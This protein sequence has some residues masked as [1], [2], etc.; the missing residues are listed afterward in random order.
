V[1]SGLPGFRFMT[2][3]GRTRRPAKWFVNEGA[4]TTGSY[5]EVKADNI[6]STGPLD[7]GGA[8]LIRLVGKTAGVD[9]TRVRTGNSSLASIGSID[10]ERR[11]YTNP[12]G[13]TDAYWGIGSNGVFSGSG[14][15]TRLN[16]G[17]FNLP[18]PSTPPHQNEFLSGRRLAT[19]RV[20]LPKFFS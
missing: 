14:M 1:M 15:A 11:E 16:A 13:I 20:A 3:T 12:F 7:S 19:N 17:N 9:H 5:L 6:I 2:T 8:G 4:I 18:F 10:D